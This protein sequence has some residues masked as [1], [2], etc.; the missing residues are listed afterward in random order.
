MTTILSSCSKPEF[1][2][3]LSKNNPAENLQ[4]QISGNGF[5][6]GLQ[7]SMAV[8]K[9]IEERKEIK[10]E[11]IYSTAD[12]IILNILNIPN[13][14]FAKKI[15]CIVHENKIIKNTQTSFVTYTWNNGNVSLL[16]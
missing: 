11:V 13:E 14:E 12:T 4:G 3:T 16:H 9:Q 8:A 5:T 7:L 1:C 6:V 2:G 10:Y 15:S